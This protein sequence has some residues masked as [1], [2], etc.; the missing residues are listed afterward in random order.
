MNIPAITACVSALHTNDYNNYVKCVQCVCVKHALPI[1]DRYPLW[2][3]SGH[4]PSSL[5]VLENN[6]FGEGD[7]FG[8]GKG[9]LALQAAWVNLT[10]VSCTLLDLWNTPTGWPSVPESILYEFSEAI[11]TAQAE[12][13]ILSS[14]TLPSAHV[15]HSDFILELLTSLRTSVPLTCKEP[16]TFNGYYDYQCSDNVTSFSKSKLNRYIGFNA[17]NHVDHIKVKQ[18]SSTHN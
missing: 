8:A 6:G 16:D 11:Q 10:R 1:S 15:T 2:L 5:A 14:F 12:V 7:G 17:I 13:I 9:H 4:S 18:N 3:S